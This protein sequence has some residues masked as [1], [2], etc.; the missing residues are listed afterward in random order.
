MTRK[1]NL[2]KND[3]E[4]LIQIVRRNRLGWLNC[5]EIGLIEGSYIDDAENL[6]RACTAALCLLG[7]EGALR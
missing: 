2:K 4:Q 7:D 3:I 6:I 1:T 5:I